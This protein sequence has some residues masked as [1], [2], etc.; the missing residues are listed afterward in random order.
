[1]VN[2]IYKLL[3]CPIVKRPYYDSPH[4][5]LQTIEWFRYFSQNLCLLLITNTVTFVE[6]QAYPP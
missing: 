1:M 6:L 4:V 5:N 2:A 3:E